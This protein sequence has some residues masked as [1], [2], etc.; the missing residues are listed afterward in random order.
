MKTKLSLLSLSAGLI[1]TA[2]SKQE[3]PAAPAATAPPPS[4]PAPA[5][6]AEAQKAA[7]T[8]QKEA[9]KTATEIQAKSEPAVTQVIK[10]PEAP[11]LP[12]TSAPQT[13]VQTVLDQVKGLLGE[14]KYPEALTALSQLSNVDLTAEQQK[15]VEQ[16]RTQIQSA[17]AAQTANEGLK[18]VGGLL[19][20]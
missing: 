16:L 12:N 14:K 11:A 17:M 20:K 7:T 8:A 13:Q 6:V 19:K 10:A 18:S 3:E 1:L 2:C 5:A 9:E 15:L 4:V